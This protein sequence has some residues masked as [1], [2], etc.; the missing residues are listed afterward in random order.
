MEKIWFACEYVRVH[1]THT[2]ITQWL[3][4]TLI[5]FGYFQSCE[6]RWHATHPQCE[7]PFLLN[8]GCCKW[9]CVQAICYTTIDWTLPPTFQWWKIGILQRI[10]FFPFLCRQPTPTGTLT[11]DT[12]LSVCVYVGVGCGWVCETLYVV[13]GNSINPYCLR[14]KLT[15]ISFKW[16]ILIFFDTHEF[17]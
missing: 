16:Q 1:R 9:L 14:A 12:G 2:G 7:Q 4:V 15:G 11:S 13:Y 10:S 3:S 5:S 6:C 8:F 17:E